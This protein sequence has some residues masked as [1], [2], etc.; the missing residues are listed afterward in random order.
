M[1]R[2][3]SLL[4]KEWN[5]AGEVQFA[6]CQLRWQSSRHFWTPYFKS[7]QHHSKW[8]IIFL[9]WILF[10]FWIAV[11]E[12]TISPQ[13]REFQN[14]DICVVSENVRFV[15]EICDF[16]SSF[17]HWTYISCVGIYTA[18]HRRNISQSLFRWYTAPRKKNQQTIA[19]RYRSE[20]DKKRVAMTNLM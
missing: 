12:K 11:A 16:C 5:W 3:S 13:N 10:L 18:S 19:Y 9:F 8:I 20:R 14:Q 6:I 1:Q 15:V 4:Q 2:M 17:W 7:Q